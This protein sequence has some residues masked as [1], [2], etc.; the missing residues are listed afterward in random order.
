MILA[1]QWEPTPPRAGSLDPQ[2]N[3]WEVVGDPFKKGRHLMVTK[4]CECGTV[5]DV[6]VNSTSLSCGC[7]RREMFAEIAT[8]HGMSYSPEY[9]AW[10]DAIH[11]CTNPHNSGYHNYGGRGIRVCDRWIES[12][13][14][15]FA[16]MGP[17]PDGMSLDRIDVNG[18]YEASNCRW[19]TWD[20]QCANRRS[21]ETCR[22]G[23]SLTPETTRMR[24]RASGKEYRQCL[25][26]VA[27]REHRRGR[28]ANYAQVIS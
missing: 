26:C 25:A 14:A 28:P 6:R 5:R 1:G 21:P 22:N 7:L 23:H 19:A 15:F 4:R 3:R 12:F 10:R 16:D 27:D 11:R 2:R 13:E 20:Q 17:R 24:T 9:R 18:N 8:T